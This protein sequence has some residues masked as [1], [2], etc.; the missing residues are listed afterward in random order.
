MINPFLASPEELQELTDGEV[1]DL[2]YQIAR[3]PNLDNQTALD[4]MKRVIEDSGTTV[5]REDN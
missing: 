2:I 3:D 1:L 5:M 4:G